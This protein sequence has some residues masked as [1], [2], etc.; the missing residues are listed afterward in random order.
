L[1]VNGATGYDQ[2]RM[3]TSFEPTGEADPRG[4]T[5]DMAW[6]DNYI[7]MKVSSGWKR[8]SLEAF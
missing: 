1:D 3:R 8:A 6:G 5:G 7:Y 4:N 2:F